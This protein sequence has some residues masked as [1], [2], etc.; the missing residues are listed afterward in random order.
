MPAAAETK[1]FEL[2]Q[3]PGPHPA[4]LLIPDLTYSFMPIWFPVLVLTPV[5]PVIL[6]GK[7]LW[8]KQTLQIPLERVSRCSEHSKILQTPAVNVE[9]LRKHAQRMEKIVPQKP[10][11]EE[12]ERPSLHILSQWTTNCRQSVA[13]NL[14]DSHCRCWLCSGTP[15]MSLWHWNLSL[16]RYISL[17][18]TEASLDLPQPWT[19]ACKLKFLLHF[20][21]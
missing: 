13:C 17:S 3:P 12:K 14:E 16:I 8:M 21:A 11:K 18:E 1:V 9:V 5:S 6:A 20:H 2:L 15:I 4:I 10:A 7:I 19:R